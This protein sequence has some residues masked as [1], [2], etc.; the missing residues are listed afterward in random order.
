MIRHPLTLILA[1]AGGLTL[2]VGLTDGQWPF[3]AA[4]AVLEAGALALVWSRLAAKPFSPPLPVA[5]VGSR[6]VLQPGAGR[7][8][9]A[10]PPVDPA[11]AEHATPEETR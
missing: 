2:I 9:V 8:T 10:S 1:I 4:G 6:V 3:L 11:P 5:P 7:V